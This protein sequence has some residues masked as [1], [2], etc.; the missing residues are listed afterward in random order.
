ME[1]LELSASTGCCDICAA[2]DGRKYKVSVA[3]GIIPVHPNSFAKD[4]EIYT[5]DGFINVSKV[6][7]GDACLSLNP[8]TFNLEYV[9][10]VNKIKHNQDKMIHSYSHNFDLLVTPEHEMFTKKRIKDHP[11]REKWE[12]VQAKDIVD[13]YA[14]YRSSEWLG[15]TNKRTLVNAVYYKT[16]LFAEFMG[17][18]LS[19]G[20]LSRGRIQ[21]AQSKKKNR[22]KY[23]RIAEVAN[24]LSVNGRV[25]Y[26]EYN[27]MLRNDS[28]Y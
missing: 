5:K 25:W 11:E 10:V 12:F 28:L 26:S 23:D 24:L 17:W 15:I 19:E 4:T 6:K 18:W 9:A 8:K 7:V 2:L 14:F 22:D 16:A 21:I 13:G 3:K 1:Q 27:V 20:S